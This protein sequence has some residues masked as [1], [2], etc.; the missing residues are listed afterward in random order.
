MNTVKEVC[1][2]K[3]ELNLKGMSSQRDGGGL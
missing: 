1:N 2:R 3:Y